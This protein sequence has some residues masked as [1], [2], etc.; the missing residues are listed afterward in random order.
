MLVL[1]R[2]TAVLAALLVAAP[3]AARGLTARERAG[4]RIYFEGKGTSGA[5]LRAFVGSGTPA[6]ASALT[7]AGCHGE[8][9]TGRP[10][11]GVLPGA[12]G[13]AELTKRYGHVHP[14][15][16][17]H[18][19][20]DARSVVRAV[21]E[22]VDPAGN[23]LGLAMPRY[24]LSREDGES[25]VAYLRVLERDA[26]PGVS[27]RALRV[28]TVL[29]TRGRLAAVGTAMRGMI[30]ASFA[31]VNAAGGIHG[32]RL[33]LAVAGYDSDAGGAV[34]AL[35]ALVAKDPPFALVS[36]L[37]PGAAAE[38]AA[39]AEQ[40][41]LPLVAPFGAA[42]P[43]ASGGRYAFYALPGVRDQARV[44]ARWMAGEGGAT[45][46]RTA[47]VHAAG[48]ALEEAARAAA[49]DLGSAGLE[50]AEVVRLEG[51]GMDAAVERLQ[52]AGVEQVI[53]LGEDPD[54]RAFTARAEALRFAPRVVA[55]GML[56]G[57]AAAE[58]P[59]SFDGRIFLAYPSLPGGGP[60]GKLDTFERLRRKAGA[61]D[62]GR[63]AQVAAFAAAAVLEEGLR[64]AGRALTRERLVDALERLYRFET[65]VVPPLSFGPARRVGALGGYVVAVDSTRGAFRPV[66]GWIA[67]E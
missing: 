26:A 20:F 35:R 36:G 23:A 38:L 59:A 24:S 41:R 12:V 49:A 45:R 21:T 13:W 54:L 30:E 28:A 66:S 47:V 25:L 42:P 6:P 62:T 46:P 61:A 27:A 51:T 11:G 58:A 55:P 67:L 63:T 31:E 65:G 52:R 3:A 48:A 60:A 10:E 15:G 64:R 22:G 7:C 56:V 18:P 43:E 39:L 57:R 16:R 17:T 4:K 50:G 8:D 34:E 32:R 9:G 53:F 19:A 1:C 40:E 29:P 5:E 2:A 33:E 37:A 44:L 14:D